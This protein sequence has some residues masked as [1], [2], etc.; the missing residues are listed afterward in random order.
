MS[1]AQAS[2]VKFDVWRLGKVHLLRLRF[3][4][5]LFFLIPLLVQAR[6][7]R[8]AHH[9]VICEAA[10]PAHHVQQ[11]QGRV[12]LV[13][14]G[15]PGQLLTGRTGC[16]GMWNIMLDEI[17]RSSLKQTQR[18]SAG[19]QALHLQRQTS[20]ALKVDKA[21]SLIEHGGKGEDNDDGETEREGNE[22]AE[23]GE[24]EIEERDEEDNEVDEKKEKG[25]GEEKGE[26]KEKD[27]HE[28]KGKEK[29]EETGEKTDNGADDKAGDEDGE[30]N[31]D[32]GSRVQCTPCR[33][34]RSIFLNQSWSVLLSFC[35]KEQGGRKLRQRA[36]VCTQ[37][38]WKSMFSLKEVSSCRISCEEHLE[39]LSAA[40]KARRLEPCSSF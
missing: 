6:H 39:I 34:L 10:R 4:N 9:G 35:R 32:E 13:C 25:K 8:R 28:V 14:F 21:E 12:K 31:P 36:F 7:S 11:I 27:E 17:L 24:D 5:G 26:Q 19:A 20:S 3:P 22:P 23:Q 15:R 29:D 33:P 38:G 18:S 37:K 16:G 30:E 40:K 2:L 1:A